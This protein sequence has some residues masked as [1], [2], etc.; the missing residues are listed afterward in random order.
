MCVRELS[1]PGHVDIH[2]WVGS[3]AANDQKALVAVELDHF[4]GG[5]PVQHRE[6]EGFE[7]R[8]FISYFPKGVHILNGHAGSA[9]HRMQAPLQRAA[10]FH[11]KGKKRPILYEVNNLTENTFRRNYK[12]DFLISSTQSNGLR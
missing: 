5:S 10:L 9:F 2:F 6:L 12:I 11:V 1:E 3:G 7:S 4:L 8:R